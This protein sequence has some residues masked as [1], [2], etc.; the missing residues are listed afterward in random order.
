MEN[1]KWIAGVLG[2]LTGRLLKIFIILID[3][4]LILAGC[5]CI[6]IGLAQWS[7]VITWIV[8]G[9]MLISL[10]FLIGKVRS[11]NAA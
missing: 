1:A 10:G 4:L 3:D 11:K 7:I 6:L 5:G 9:G 2:L 8:G